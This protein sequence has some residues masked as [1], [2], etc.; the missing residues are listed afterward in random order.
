MRLAL[1]A[2]LPFLLPGCGDPGPAECRDLDSGITCERLTSYALFSGNPA[3]LQPAAGVVPFA[4]ASALFSDYALKSRF[5]YLPPGTRAR[6]ADPEPFVF[7]DGA[8]VV[9]TFA[10]PDPARASGRRLL[11]TRLLLKRKSGWEAVPFVWNDEQTEATLRPVGQVVPVR[12][13]LAGGPEHRIGYVVPNTNQCKECHEDAGKVSAPIGLKARHLNHDYAYPQGPENQLAH[14]AKLGILEGA[15]PPEQ[16]PRL[17]AWDDDRAPLGER[18][19]SWLEINCA[20]CHN[21]AGQARNTGLDLMASQLHAYEYGVCKSPVA[22]GKGTGGHQYNIV[23]GKPDDSILQFRIE[24]TLPGVMM[25][26]TGRQ[27]PHA[28]GIA[29]VRQWIASLPGGCP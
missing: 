6:Y 22:A 19:R 28:E 4:P 13:A 20:H 15:P 18:A 16:A 2:A 25:P 3:D 7:P 1:A 9:K 24:S 26:E 8:I 11:E 12:F 21:P 23:P 10:Y 5:V 27:L 14:W 29:L 17:A